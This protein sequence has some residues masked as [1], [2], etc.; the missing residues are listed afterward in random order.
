M[1]REIQSLGLERYMKLS[2]CER[3]FAV[4]KSQC[5][6]CVRGERITAGT[7]RTL[8]LDKTSRIEIADVVIESHI[9]GVRSLSIGLKIAQMLLHLRTPLSRRCGPI[10][11]P[12]ELLT[13]VSN[14]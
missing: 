3:V 10:P 12:V 1:N 11:C 4:T 9:E 7:S 2:K 6:S 8:Q 14:L 5:L 13:H